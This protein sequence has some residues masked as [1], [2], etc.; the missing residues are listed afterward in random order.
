[1]RVF[2]VVFGDKKILVRQFARTFDC[3]GQEI[4]CHNLFS[5]PKMAEIL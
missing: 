4:C 5:I 1:M 2:A 3:A